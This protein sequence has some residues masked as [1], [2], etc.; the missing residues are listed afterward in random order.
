MDKMARHGDQQTHD[1]AGLHRKW[2]VLQGAGLKLQMW[3]GLAPGRGDD[4]R[5]VDPVDDRRRR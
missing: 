2:D 4:D 3:N 5:Q 1:L